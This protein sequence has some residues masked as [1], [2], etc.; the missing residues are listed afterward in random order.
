MDRVFEAERR[1]A[2]INKVDDDEKEWIANEH[3][4]FLEGMALTRPR[5]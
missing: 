3:F 1:F 4:N 2:E 5:S